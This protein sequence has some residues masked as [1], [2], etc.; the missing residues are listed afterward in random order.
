MNCFGVQK[1]DE[2][3][4]CAKCPKK[5][6]TRNALSSHM[7]VHSPKANQPAQCS[8]CYQIFDNRRQ[9]TEHLKTHNQFCYGSHNSRLIDDSG[10]IRNIDLNLPAG[11]VYPYNR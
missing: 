7:K 4:Q 8:Q 11:P 10:V 3:Y 2:E 5:F 9:L 1:Q 6:I